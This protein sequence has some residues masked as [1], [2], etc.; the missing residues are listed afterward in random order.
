M[1]T[2][3]NTNPI[4]TTAADRDIADRI[5]NAMIVKQVT[6]RTLS[7]ETGISYPTLRR[8]LK[9]NRSFTFREF[10]RIAAVLTLKPSVLLP[11][12]LADAA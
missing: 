2:P 6:Q 12:D 9:G 8:S 7:E 1:N 5:L 10:Y 3:D 4:G 11:A